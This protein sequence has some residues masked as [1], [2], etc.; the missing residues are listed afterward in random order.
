MITV[1]DI[2]K[3]YLIANGYDGLY[4]EDCGCVVDDL[5]PCGDC[6]DNCIPGYK[7]DH[8]GCGCGCTEHIGPKE[9]E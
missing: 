4:N 5:I 8:C 9:E 3:Q 7:W 6:F 2:V 1:L